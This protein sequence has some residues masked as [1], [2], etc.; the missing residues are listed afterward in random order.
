MDTTPVFA[1]PY[2]EPTDPITDYPA[3]GQDLAERLEAL[4]EPLAEVELSGVAASFDVLGLSAFTEYHDLR[5]VLSLRGDIAAAGAAVRIRLNNDSGANYDNAWMRG[6]TTADAGEALG[7]AYAY[8]GD[9]P[10]AT[11]IANAFSTHE[12]LLV[13]FR[14]AARLKHGHGLTYQHYSNASGDQRI[15]GYGFDWRSIA[16][17]DRATIFPSSGNFV[18]GSSLRIYGQK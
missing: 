11:A 1:L 7:Q 2:P 17:V 14:N 15:M 10:G 12:I 4:L 6:R 3:L 18:A 8:L 16:A 5:F 13:D 9:C